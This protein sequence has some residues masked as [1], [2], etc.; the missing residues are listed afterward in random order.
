MSTTGSEFSTVRYE[1]PTVRYELPIIRYE[2][3]TIRYE[4]FPVRI[5]ALNKNKN[6]T[7]HNIVCTKCHPSL[8][9]LSR[10]RR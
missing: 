8:Y 10:L 2:L 3:S 7:V 5:N 1:L 9:P 4:F 6:K